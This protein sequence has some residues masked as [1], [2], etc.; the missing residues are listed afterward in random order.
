MEGI[1]ELHSEVWAIMI[2]IFIFVSYM[3]AIS[4]WNFNDLRNTKKPFKVVHNNLIEVV[5]TLIPTFI[6]IFM[7]IPSFALLYSLDEQINPSLT[8]KVTGSQWYWNYS[9]AD[10]SLGDDFDLEG[11]Q[12]DSYALSDDLLEKGNMRLLDVDCR[13][14]LPVNTYIR[15]LTTS[16]DVIHS[17][18]VPSLGLKLD[19]IPGRLNQTLFIINRQGIFAGQCSELC[20]ANHYMMPI[21]VESVHKKDFISWANNKLNS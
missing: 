20:G 17:F 19:S 9:Y 12:Y 21:I 7:T 18:A 10:F 15:L 13:L 8:I 5:W 3:M 14:V 1:I 4:I 11:I 6:L 16:T 2:G